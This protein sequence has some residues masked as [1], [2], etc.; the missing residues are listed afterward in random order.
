VDKEYNMQLQEGAQGAKTTQMQGKQ[1]RMMLKKI[2]F[3]ECSARSRSVLTRQRQGQ[4]RVGR[5]KGKDKDKDKDKD[6][7]GQGQGQGQGQATNKQLNNSAR[8]FEIELLLNLNSNSVYETNTIK[9]GRSSPGR[10]SLFLSSL[11]C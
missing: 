6:K 2:F 7:Q 9:Q 4:A 3:L 5:S 10:S 1:L 8:Q 11:S